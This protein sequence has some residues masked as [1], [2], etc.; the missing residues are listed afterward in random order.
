[1]PQSSRPSSWLDRSRRSSTISAPV[2]TA[3][4]TPSALTPY[5]ALLAYVL[6]YPIRSD[7]G[8]GV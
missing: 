8:W 1:M 5:D 6:S 3:T 7:P 4:P 2:G